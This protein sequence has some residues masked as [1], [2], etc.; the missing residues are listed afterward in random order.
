VNLKR[1]RSRTKIAH[2]SPL[3]LVEMTRKR[4]GETFS[5]LTMEPCHYCNGRG[6]TLNPDTVSILAE[7]EIFKQVLEVDD[8][9]FLV[10]V[11]PNVAP[12]LIGPDGV[13]VDRLESDVRRGV[14][15]RAQENLH[16]EKFEVVP[17]DMQEMER[18][19]LPYRE[20][21]IVDCVVESSPAINL[22]HAVARIDGYLLDLSNGGQYLG[23]RVRARLNKVGRSI[24]MAEVVSSG[25]NVDKRG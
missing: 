6:R 18:Q 17:A 13:N 11:H 3:G 4:T 7:R 24:A 10:M 22:P 19:L 8:E 1:D 5:T 16:I 14:Y 23:R 21:Q 2:L 20:G 15:V 9:A 25:R 12:Y